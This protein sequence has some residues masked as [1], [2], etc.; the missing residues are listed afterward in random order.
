MNIFHILSTKQGLFVEN[1]KGLML[2]LYTVCYIA[3][4][5]LG[6]LCFLLIEGPQED[7]MHKNM[8]VAKA[9]LIKKHPGVTEDALDEFLNDVTSFRVRGVISPNATTKWTYSEAVFFSVTLLTTIGYGHV[10]PVSPLGKATCMVYT[11][12]G[13]PFT[14][15]LLAA[16]VQRLMNASEVFKRILFCSLKNVVKPVV[17]HF[18]HVGTIIA[19]IVILCFLIPAIVFS[20]LE[21]GWSYLDALYFCF[22][23]LTTVGLGDFV[24]SLSP[25]QS[26][27]DLYRFAVTFYV[28][29]GVTA[30]MFM[31]SLTAEFQQNFTRCQHEVIMPQLFT[32][33]KIPINHN[34]AARLNMYGTILVH[35]PNITKETDKNKHIIRP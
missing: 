6:G 12:F 34:N 18:I 26:Y 28:V 8:M 21:A 4:V 3:Y 29:A 33:E 25:N 19:S 35:N 22:I 5:A 30:M 23:S 2:L 13:I 9:N 31:M 1:R 10:A 20:H 14:L 16:Y 32:T 11:G 7:A 17:I 24:P 27:S 15:L